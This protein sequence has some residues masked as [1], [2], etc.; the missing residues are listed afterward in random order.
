MNTLKKVAAVNIIALAS[1][2]LVP[3]T[4][5]ANHTPPPV[6]EVDTATLDEN[7]PV[8]GQTF[9]MYFWVRDSEVGHASTP[10][11]GTTL[12]IR[13]RVGDCQVDFERGGL[14]KA[15]IDNVNFPAGYFYG[16]FVWD[17]R[18]L[19][20]NFV[21]RGTYCYRLRTFAND[22]V[23]G[24]IPVANTPF[25]GTIF[26]ENQTGAVI[27]PPAWKAVPISQVLTHSVSGSQLTLPGSVTISYTA[28]QT[29]RNGLTLKI[30]N[31]A[32]LV[33]SVGTRVG[34]VAPDSSGSF[35]WNGK[36]NSN[37]DVAPGTY[38]YRFVTVDAGQELNL[39]QGNIVVQTTPPPPPAPAC[40]DG[41]DNDGDS[42]IDLA[43][44]GCVN[45][46]DN[47]E[48]NVA[49]NVVVSNIVA[50][51]ATFSPADGPIF[52]S[53][54]Y[55]L[56]QPARVS[57]EIWRSGTRH[58]T[59]V[60]MPGPG[61]ANNGSAG[62][63]SAPNWGG[64]SDSFGR[65]LD[66]STDDGPYEIRVS[67]VGSNGVLVVR[68]GSVAIDNG[69]PPVVMDVSNVRVSPT[70]FSPLAGGVV[71]IFYTLNEP[72]NDVELY[73]YDNL[74]L[75][76]IDNVGTTGATGQNVTTWDGYSSA[77]G[78]FLNLGSDSKTYT[79][80]IQAFAVDGTND[81]DFTDVT[82]NNV[83]SQ[84]LVIS[85]VSAS[86]SPF[87]PLN[88]QTTTVSF[89]VSAPATNVSATIMNTSG[90]T[91][92]TASFSG[93]IAQG[94][95][96]FV[97]SGINDQGR[98]LTQTGD[99][100]AYTIRINGTGANGVSVSSTPGSVSISNTVGTFS[101]TDQGPS[102]NP[103][104]P[105]VE[106]TNLQYTM[107][108][109]ADVRIRVYAPGT[110]PTPSSSLSPIRTLLSSTFRSSGAK[111]EAW[112]GRDDSGNLVVSSS[113]PYLVEATS[114]QNGASAYFVGYVSV[115]RSG[116]ITITD[117]GP[118]RFTFNPSLGQTVTIR[119]ELNQADAPTVAILQ[120]GATGTSLG[121]LGVS[122]ESSSSGRYVY[123]AVW[124]GRNASNNIVANDTYAY[125]IRATS[126][127]S[128]QER[129]GYVRVDNGIGGGTGTGCS[130]YSDVASNDPLCP[131]I[132]F[133]VSRGIFLGDAGR[134]TLRPGDRL[135]RAETAKVLQS[136]FGY[137][138]ES[139]DEFRDDDLG[140]SDLDESAWYMPYMKTFIIR[141]VMRG[142]PDGKMRP[143]QKMKTTELFKIFVEGI[144]EAP[145][146]LANFSLNRNV[147]QAPFNDTPVRSDTK[148][149]LPYAEFAERYNL[150]PSE[151]YFYPAREITRGKVILLIYESSSKNVISYG[152]TNP[153]ARTAS[154]FT[155][156]Y[157][158]RS[159]TYYRSSSSGSYGTDSIY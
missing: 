36:N 123:R 8:G 150:A 131:A 93:T 76:H 15:L 128:T 52:T 156:T 12:E 147:R 21:P 53:I 46:A 14:I 43:D 95:Y 119:F 101:L 10:A 79:I 96:Q 137:S 115:N 58:Y 1:S 133:V 102:R 81:Y 62:V 126:G 89:N 83:A 111:F 69:E 85:N 140:F 6:L 139:Y 75:V 153:S 103:F 114:R 65:F 135:S 70:T 138:L 50:S 91:V 136:A 87:S 39:G 7:G 45:A 144:F 35:Q 122:L 63:N 2:F 142:Y 59:L 30:M 77:L 44:L 54:S 116:V 88:G 20:G 31:G 158:E 49:G 110:S 56:D 78:R 100:G 33:R 26:A 68:S 113:Y 42:R 9:K 149:Y 5:L 84:N 25:F 141:G 34:P 82:V 18:D 124:N 127:G 146:A 157:G 117:L 4:A 151:P 86:P 121:T 24:I 11:V 130:G 152:V 38:Q 107:N 105:E 104:N 64:W 29:I 66:L 134:N 60:N 23:R 97:W 155:Y 74:D 112:N 92:Y 106:S 148:W 55:T 108:H 154:Q 3:L 80:I 109:D 16:P 47:D 32:T 19:G 61:V 94:Q 90:S 99:N 17:G 22:P 159:P 37:V 71:N 57:V 120:G 98:Y 28:H 27:S 143:I 67:A 145:R 72:S 73:V 51:P 41:V 13:T 125:R 40:S 48:T 129:I 118:D 132:Q